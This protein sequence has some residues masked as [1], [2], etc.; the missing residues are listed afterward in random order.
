[1]QLDACQGDC[2]NRGHWLLPLVG[3][4]M[5][6]A[7]RIRSESSGAFSTGRMGVASSHKIIEG[8]SIKITRHAVQP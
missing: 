4:Q 3:T 1:M 8:N 5:M 6:Q 7:G 2:I